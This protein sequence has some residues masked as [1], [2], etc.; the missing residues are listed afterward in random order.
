VL[1]AAVVLAAAAPA[2]AAPELVKLGD[3][4]DPVHVA[5]PPNDPRVFVVERGGLVK[6]AGGGTFIDLTGPTNS[7]ASER[8]LL[9]IAF[10]PDYATSG[11]FYVFLTS[12][13]AGDVEVREYRRSAADPNVADP[14]PV[15]TLLD[16]PHSAGNHNGGQLQFGPDGALYA[17]IGDNASAPTPRARARRSG[18]SIASTRSREPARCGHRACA[19]RGGSRST[20]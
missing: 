7:G 5:S 14:A 6:I 18:R 1:A 15:R 3:F 9:S 16:E 19:T 13:P 11:R 20:A 17:S 12:D 2:S 10:P 8:G 4:T